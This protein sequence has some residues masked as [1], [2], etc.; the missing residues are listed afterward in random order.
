MAGDTVDLFFSI[1]LFSTNVLI[2]LY[3][4]VEALRKPRGVHLPESD[5]AEV[6]PDKDK[7]KKEA[8][9]FSSFS[10]FG[11]R[12]RRKADHLVR[13]LILNDASCAAA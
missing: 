5:A 7:A 2:V 3:T 4:A 8:G 12:S 13:A 10:S 6:E 9:S 11:S 1:V